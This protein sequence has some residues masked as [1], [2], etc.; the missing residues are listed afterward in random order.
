[1]VS[2]QKHRSVEHGRS[3]MKQCN[4]IQVLAHDHFS[5][6]NYGFEKGTIDYEGNNFHLT[7][8]SEVAESLE[9]YAKRSTSSGD[10]LH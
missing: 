6:L 2:W 5:K 3:V 7:F 4:E 1:M 9:F 8:R 10:S